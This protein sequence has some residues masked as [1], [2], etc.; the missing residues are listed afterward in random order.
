MSFEIVRLRSQE[1]HAS[2]DS[3]F[4]ET[5]LEGLSR[6]EKCLPS[7]LIF[8]DRGSEIFKELTELE[9]YH[10]SVCEKE[11][12]LSHKEVI[13]AIV[14]P[15][16]FRLIDL[17]S[18]EGSKT[19][20]LIDQFLKNNL[21]FEYIPIDL[22][23]GAVTDL[24]AGL[25]EKYSATSLTVKGAV[26][27]YFQGLE[28]FAGSG[29][30]RNFALFQGATIG[31]RDLAEVKTWLRRLANALNPGDYVM[32]AFDLMKPPKLLY[33]SY[34]DPQGIF[35][36][37]NL[38][39]LDRINR[40]LGA[41]FNIANYVQ[42]AIYNW[43]TRSVE[44]YIYSVKDQ[45]VRVKALDREFFFKQG[46]GMRTEQSYKFTIEEIDGLAEE[47]GFAVMERLFDARKYCVSPIWQ[48]K[49]R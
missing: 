14:A 26:A 23:A 28:E 43:R 25:R 48:V 31:N 4:A 42:E 38:H 6:K 12:L 45:R 29:G 9:S 18:G 24:V 35:E 19:R 47:S 5:V 44:S 1:G 37:F 27:D 15:G 22:S 11:I 33:R 39:V 17:G 3:H 30:K 8:D 21:Q 2:A 41:D 16:P 10:A 49:P 34:N 32:V 20:I 36:K 13:S 46:E 40:Q 7:W